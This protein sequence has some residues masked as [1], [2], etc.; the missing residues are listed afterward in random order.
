MKEGTGYLEESPGQ[1]SMGRLLGLVGGVVGA[2]VT[3]AGCVL[4]FVEALERTGTAHGLALAGIGTGMFTSGA[5]GK[6]WGK[7][8]EAS[9][10]VAELAQPAELP[11]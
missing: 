11:R 1:R 2:A 6:A 5:L 3:V 8:A 4:A 7:Q 9:V 10:E